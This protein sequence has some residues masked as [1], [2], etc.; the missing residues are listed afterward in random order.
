MFEGFEVDL[1][2]W[3]G[4]EHWSGCVYETEKEFFDDVRAAL[5]EMSGG[6]ADIWDADGE[7]Y[8]EIEV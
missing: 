1:D 5:K 3:D 2:C 8:A 4:Y 6:H 7:L